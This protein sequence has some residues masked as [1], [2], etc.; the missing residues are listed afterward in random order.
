M[1]SQDQLGWNMGPLCLGLLA[2]ISAG[3]RILLL[4]VWLLVLY[5]A[6][7]HV[8]VST[9]AVCFMLI[10]SND[11][12][13]TLKLSTSFSSLNTIGFGTETVLKKER[14]QKHYFPSI[15]FQL[16]IHTW[17]PG[18]LF[19]SAEAIQ[20]KA[21]RLPPLAWA[22]ACSLLQASWAGVKF[23]AN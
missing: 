8:V 13:L 14:K 12:Y 6:K 7:W 19:P 18:Q 5:L 9:V 10:A 3:I 4:L 23:R 11:T 17:R 21:W 15:H 20:C 16:E 22:P 2:C 1:L